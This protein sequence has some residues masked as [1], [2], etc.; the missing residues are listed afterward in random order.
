MLFSA[1]A[2]KAGTIA[3]IAPGSLALPEMHAVVCIHKVAANALNS[4]PPPTQRAPICPPPHR[5]RRHRTGAPK[6]LNSEA[7]EFTINAL[8]A[9]RA[10]LDFFLSKV[11]SDALREARAEIKAE[12]GGES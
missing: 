1:C 3:K 11:P 9:T 5:A 7:L 12:G 6:K 2:T 4:P 8:G 10:K